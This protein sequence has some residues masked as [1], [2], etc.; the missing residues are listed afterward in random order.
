M[1]REGFIKRN[2]NRLAITGA[3]TVLAAGATT[4]IIET[5]ETPNRSTT[6]ISQIQKG[7]ASKEVA[8][9]TMTKKEGHIVK[10]EKHN[11]Q[12]R[13][14]LGYTLEKANKNTLAIIG[15]DLKM[16]N[17]L[18]RTAEQNAHNGL[19]ELMRDGLIV[20]EV[21]SPN[22]PNHERGDLLV[23]EVK[24]VNLDDMGNKPIHRHLGTTRIRKLTTIGI[25]FL[26]VN[27]FKRKLLPL[28]IPKL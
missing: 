18:V 5:H 25:K 26:N 23:V 6:S 11:Q 10:I 28:L 22:L 3:A 15:K 27:N 21:K 24:D 12:K 4:A 9:V 8:N 1:E 20:K 2:K 13:L 19:D 7:E 16:P 17:K 14:D